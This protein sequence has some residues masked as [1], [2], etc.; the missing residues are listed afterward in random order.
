M[1]VGQLIKKL[2]KINKRREVVLQIDSEGNGFHKLE[3]VDDNA[4]YDDDLD[5]G[6]EV[7]VQ[8]LTKEL[9]KQGF[10]EEDLAPKGS[11]PCVVLFP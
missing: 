3:G 9:K 6:I 10:G 5:Y 8:K 1:T 4:A 7:G 2:E 11:T